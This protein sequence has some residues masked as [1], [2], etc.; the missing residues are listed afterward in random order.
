[1]PINSAT[2]D[3]AN[4]SGNQEQ[5]RSTIQIIKFFALFRI[6][7][8]ISLPIFALL[9]Q[10]RSHDIHE[11]NNYT[12]KINHNSGFSSAFVHPIYTLRHLK[13]GRFFLQSYQSSF[14]KNVDCEY[15]SLFARYGD[16]GLLDAYKGPGFFHLPPLVLA[17]WEPIF[18]LSDLLNQLICGKSC[19]Y[20]QNDENEPVDV[21]CCDD[22]ALHSCILEVSFGLIF[23]FVDLLTAYLLMSLSQKMLNLRY[24]GNS[25]YSLN[26]KSYHSLKLYPNSIS[27]NGESNATQNEKKS[28]DAIIIEYSPN[29]LAKINENFESYEMEMECLMEG[30]I[31]PINGYLFG[32]PSTNDEDFYNKCIPKIT[33]P[34][35]SIESKLQSDLI[36]N[37][38]EQNKAYMKTNAID[39]TKIFIHQEQGDQANKT[40]K[41]TNHNEQTI[42]PIVNI[43]QILFLIYFCNPITIASSTFFHSF[44]GLYFLLYLGCLHS[45]Y[46]QNGP[47]GSLLLAIWFHIDFFHPI[48][49]LIP[50]ILLVRRKHG[51]Q[52]SILGCVVYFLLWS[53]L[54]FQIS[55]LLLSSSGCANQNHF[56]NSD[57]GGQMNTI[58]R[59]M[60]HPHVYNLKNE[61]NSPNLGMLWYFYMQ[62]FD[63]FK[64]FY[65]V[66]FL[67]LPTIMAI[68]L[69]IRLWRYPIELVRIFFSFLITTTESH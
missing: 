63:R 1:M 41:E 4:F 34:S 9:I 24:Q 52:K 26:C 57:D 47:L 36:E 51:I 56:N 61:G 54:L 38:N 29:L 46:S 68:P 2:K 31:R 64:D 50:F 23:V 14:N 30:R 12:S 16:G 21:R 66:F 39:K 40:T 32:I 17:L 19:S 49:F 42:M 35:S 62:I 48:L 37:R 25:F 44:Q 60:I 43:P 65:T 45:A 5:R 7:L 6:T 27:K 8:A 10:N 3:V 55:F 11:T 15:T 53:C 20:I 22:S 67:T 28:I 33:A 58:W 69:S 13:E 18:L 59:E